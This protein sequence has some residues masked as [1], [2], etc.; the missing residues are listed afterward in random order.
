MLIT[1]CRIRSDYWR[2]LDKEGWF[3]FDCTVGS[4]GKS[5]AP[6]AP[7]W[8]MVKGYLQKRM[9]EEEYTRR[10]HQMMRQSYLS[11]RKDW[12]ELLEHEKVALA[13]YCGENEFCHRHL[14]AEYLQK[15]GEA[16]GIEVDIVY[17]EGRDY[18]DDID[19]PNYEQM[20]AKYGED[21]AAIYSDP[22]ED[23][24][25]RELEQLELEWRN[26]LR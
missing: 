12:N 19:E 7:T 5:A 15:A 14:L 6:F 3:V 10:Y 8:E 26:K 23:A 2:Q 16:N 21:Q 11:H 24:Y 1:T 18:G 25:E 22:V 9:T 20:K 13:C 4:G 17:E